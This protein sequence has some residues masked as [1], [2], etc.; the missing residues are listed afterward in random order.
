MTPH[1]R[2]IVLV[3]IIVVLIVIGVASI[4]I[5]KRQRKYYA[6]EEENSQV[7]ILNEGK[8][9]LFD[10]IKEK[11]GINGDSSSR[12][13]NKRKRTPKIKIEQTHCKICGRELI[14]GQCSNEFCI[15]YKRVVFSK[16]AKYFK[17]DLSKL[18]TIEV[19]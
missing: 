17:F 8:N 13:L 19:E 9:N 3:I 6:L 11:I 7:N 18:G 1:K 12:E 15:K 2:G 14:N 4:F 10:K 5:I 16:L